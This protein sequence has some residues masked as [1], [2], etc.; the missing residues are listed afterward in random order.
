MTSRFVLAGDQLL[1]DPAFERTTFTVF[2]SNEDM[3]K[4]IEFLYSQRFF[5]RRSGSLVAGN[6][7]EDC[8]AVEVCLDECERFM[9]P[10]GEDN[11][12]FAA[13][14]RR[15]HDTLKKNLWQLLYPGGDF[16]KW[17]ENRYAWWNEHVEY[18]ERT[19]RFLDELTVAFETLPD[20]V[21][22]ACMDWL[23][24]QP[25]LSE[26][27]DESTLNHLLPEL[28]TRYKI[29]VVVEGV[30]DLIVT[31]KNPELIKPMARYLYGTYGEKAFPIL[32]KAVLAL[33]EVETS[34]E[35]ERW[36]VRAVAADVAFEKGERLVPRLIDLLRDEWPEVRHAAIRS[37]VAIGNRACRVALTEVMD[38]GDSEMKMALLDALNTS[39]S[40]WALAFYEKAL[41]SKDER[42]W[43]VAFKGLTQQKSPQAATIII[44][45]V[46]RFELASAEARM[47]VEALR[48]LGGQGARTAL[49]TVL[50]DCEDPELAKRIALGLAELGE[51]SVFPRLGDCM[52]ERDLRERALD[53]MAFLLVADFEDDFFQYQGL[54]EKYPG[55][56]QAFFL[57][58]ALGL[59][60]PAGPDQKSIEGI[61]I[62][63]LVAALSDESWPVKLAALRLLE[64]GTGKTFGTLTKTSDEVAIN[65]VSGA[66]N[67]WFEGVG[68]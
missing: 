21:I 31:T 7:P 22:L 50:E 55:E 8:K 60:G 38:G 47:G 32:G 68:K 12:E 51:T 20:E 6:T 27:L 37:L 1:K 65:T 40:P 46:R 11:S 66:W 56:S 2:L 62:S 15:L 61:P 17:W 41:D 45:F 30:A 36:F 39:S 16:Y 52:F 5:N 4:I 23:K 24:E 58:R 49:L 42:F 26:S 43:A 44:E 48:K 13:I 54:W 29:D 53:A 18:K 64:E 63:V 28:D 35:D 33:D 34:L 59:A 19:D 9:V 67:A 10:T 3:T 14:E 57:M 25:S